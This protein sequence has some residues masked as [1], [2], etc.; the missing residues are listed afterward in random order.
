MRKVI[1]IL[2]FVLPAG[3]LLAQQDPQFSQYMFNTLYFN[4]GF[5]GV[6]GVT[7]LTAIHRSQWLGY[8]PTLGGGGAPTTQIISMTTPLFKINSGFGAYVLNDKL[9]PQNNLEAQASYAYHLGIKDSKLSFGL[10]AGLY[11]QTIDFNQYRATDPSDPLLNATGKESQIRPDLAMGVFFRK[12]KYYVGAS[13][14]HLIKSTFDFGLSQRNALQSHLYLTGG[15]FY[16]LNFDL[17]FQF[18]GLVKSDF[19]KTSF[20]V[21]GLAY[22][23]DTMWGGLSFRQSEA[24]IVL[25]GYSLLKDKSLKLGYALDV[26]IKDQQAKQPTSHEFMLTYELPVNP[27]SGKKVVRTPRYRH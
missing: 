13:F 21:G 2:F 22:F 12:E 24:A 20:D 15:Y 23:K 6:D 27:G 11:S 7:K 1:I 25:L 10:R 14:S 8:Q 18:T 5:A 9:G 19:T 4:P 3:N 26:I 16:E 17:R